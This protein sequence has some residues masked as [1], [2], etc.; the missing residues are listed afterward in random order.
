MNVEPGERCICQY[1]DW[2]N[3]F[4]DKTTA[5]Q[6]GMRL[7]VIATKR[8]AGASFYAFKETPE[9]NFFLSTGFKPMRNL[10]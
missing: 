4:G 8:I 3:A 9:D 2:F 5:V 1:D 7:T 6:T 10:Q